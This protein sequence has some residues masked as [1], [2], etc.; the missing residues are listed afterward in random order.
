[1]ALIEDLTALIAPPYA[2]S[3]VTRDWEAIDADLGFVTPL[4]YREIVET[5]GSGKFDDF[6]MVLMPQDSNIHLDLGSQISGWRDALRM[7]LDSERLL[8][9]PP[10]VVPYPIESLTACAYTDNGDV[11]YW[12]T[13]E[14]ADPNEWPVVIQATRD[15]E[16][17]KF[18]GSLLEFLDSVFSQTY[19]CPIF[20]DDFPEQDG[21][22]FTPSA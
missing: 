11:I 6:L 15:D 18:D 5:Y 20:P 4:D 1:M 14:S 9:V 19:F 16:W 8:G 21:S 22:Y 3:R 2:A 17:D 7:S 10:A 13:S 12:L